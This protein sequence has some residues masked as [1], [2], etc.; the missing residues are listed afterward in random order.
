M[1]DPRPTEHFLDLL[2][3]SEEVM[4]AEMES[5]GFIAALNERKEDEEH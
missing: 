3:K 5:G 2:L 4:H 1:A